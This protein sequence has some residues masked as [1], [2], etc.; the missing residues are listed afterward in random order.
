VD[1]YQRKVSAPGACASEF[2]LY[3]T[4][5][6]DDECGNTDDFTQT[7]TVTDRVDPTFVT[8]P[9]ATTHICNET[10]T[11]P[12][13]NIN[14][15]CETDRVDPD[16]SEGPNG[17][18]D[19][20]TGSWIR[21]DKW[22]GYD[23]CGNDVY[24][25][26]EVTFTD[27]YD[28]VWDSKLPQNKTIS[29]GEI[30]PAEKLYC[31][32]TCDTTV[33]TTPKD[34]HEVEQ[35]ECDDNV[36]KI[37]RTWTCCDCSNNCIKH[38]QE[39]TVV[40]NEAPEFP[41]PPEHLSNDD[42]ECTSFYPG[43]EIPAPATFGPDNTRVE[44]TKCTSE[45]AQTAD[46]GCT[47]VDGGSIQWPAQSGSV[48][49]L[50]FTEPATV[51]S[52]VDGIYF[53]GELVEA[54][55]PANKW[56]IFFDLRGPVDASVTK[57]YD[58]FDNTCPTAADGLTAFT[59][60]S[61]GRIWA[62]AGTPVQGAS[63]TASNIKAF[64]GIGGSAA[65]TTGIS[66]ESSWALDGNGN[67]RSDEASRYAV[68]NPRV[69]LQHTTN[70]IEGED[71]SQCT[72][73]VQTDVET[74]RTNTSCDQEYSWNR[75][76][77][78][79][80]CANN[81]A[82]LSFIHNVV[83]T[84]D[85]EL[86]LKFKD[87]NVPLTNTTVECND[88]PLPEA[89]MS[90]TDNCQSVTPN[91]YDV[92]PER[93]G[94]CG[95][96]TKVYKFNVTDC[97]GNTDEMYWT[98]TVEDTEKP[99][100]TND[101]PPPGALTLDCEDETNRGDYTFEDLFGEDDCSITNTTA[102]KDQGPIMENGCHSNYTYV[103][104]W[105]ITDDCDLQETHR[106]TVTVKDN[107]PPT[108]YPPDS[109][110]L[111]PSRL[112][113]FYIVDKYAVNGEHW[114]ANDTC[115]DDP[116]IVITGCTSDQ[117]DFYHPGFTGDFI[118]DCQYFGGALDKLQIR[119]RILNNRTRGRMFNI[120][121]R[122][123]DACTHMSEE[124]WTTIFI[125]LNNAS[126]TERG[127]E[128]DTECVDVV[129]C[130]QVCPCEYNG[131]EECLDQPEANG[132]TATTSAPVVANGNTKF[133]YNV[134]HQLPPIFGLSTSFQL[135]LPLAQLDIVSCKVDGG[136][137]DCSFIHPTGAHIG[138]INAVLNVGLVPNQ[139]IQTTVELT[140][141]GTQLSTG[142]VPFTVL[143]GADPVSRQI[144][145]FCNHGE[146]TAPTG[147][148]TFAN[149]GF[150]GGSVQ[151]SGRYSANGETDF[152]NIAPI[153][154]VVVELTGPVIDTQL[155]AFPVIATT[156]TDHDGKFHF[157]G[158]PTGDYKIA[159]R[160]V[161][162][163]HGTGSGQF[164]PGLS[165]Y[166]T[167]RSHVSL[168]GYPFGP[169]AAVTLGASDNVIQLDIDDTRVIRGTHYY[170]YEQDEPESFRGNPHSRAYWQYQMNVA[171]N[172]FPGKNAAGFAGHVT[173]AKN[174][175]ASAASCDI[176]DF[177]VLSGDDLRSNLSAAALNH[178][179]G[180]GVLDPLRQVQQL[181][182]QYAAEALCRG[183]DNARAAEMVDALM[184]AN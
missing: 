114:F 146:I 26:R 60:A 71:R 87:T 65:G 21:T 83:D 61:I 2:V 171:N 113:S 101:P 180:R 172:V 35:K 56:N 150:V 19:K 151:L 88:I 129:D 133:T 14:D 102:D 33:A 97:V 104:T 141:R 160:A 162:S 105:T 161:D 75:T 42:E 82:S 91:M 64:Y 156:L 148:G 45:A 123:V 110:C 145:L 183:Q 78:L 23:A 111:A 80:D 119:V 179:S 155:Q 62:K 93:M 63:Y 181:T 31:S 58:L 18:C 144:S 140:V 79:T 86:D 164:T 138:G 12:T 32:D 107:A 168:F 25:D 54:G 92:S 50:L 152:D 84:T 43:F 95:N 98:I 134:V 85:P 44:T 178:V 159:I 116:T 120:T 4:W 81:S 100:F 69:S 34:A 66:I 59:G 143:T 77:S 51:L 115:D 121:A 182:I 158:L 68:T 40:D 166:V 131:F 126:F 174:L 57:P 127:L 72:L 103:R 99:D 106:Q 135:G 163:L 36:K 73:D 130:T 17:E 94:T 154:D 11:Q 132:W 96:Y 90:A 7:I 74:I 173:A 15:N 28:P 37:I 136:A 3:R 118:P 149:S 6:A 47:L 5:V 27:P 46:E 125:P 169:P 48:I 175:I 117:D 147:G 124:K 16:F 89:D 29:C 109:S 49:V 52:F 122:S 20:A 139:D 38:V 39:I 128:V 13:L 30:E 112:D 167:E 53:Y 9:G 1:F 55:N 184:R 24:H 22:T 165:H 67:D 142:V 157:D 153:G 108:I 70:C 170:L 137:R 41:F 176:N 8:E 76:Y 177:D 10:Y